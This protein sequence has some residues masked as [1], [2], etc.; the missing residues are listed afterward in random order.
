VDGTP[1]AAPPGERRDLSG[2]T[3]AGRYL[4]ERCLGVGGMGAVYVARH[5]TLGAQVA[6]K[7]LLP[8][9]VNARSMARF[10][11]EAQAASRVDHE[12]VIGVLDF[13]Q[14][15]A[16][17][18]FLVMEYV[19]GL[20][21]DEEIRRAG[22]F[23][24]ER[25]LHVLAQ[26]A[27]GLARTHELGIIHR[28]LK[29]ENVLLCERRGDR[30][31]VKLI[32][33]GL[34]KALHVEP[35]EALLT[36]EGDVFGTPEYMPPEQWRGGATDARSDIYSFGVLAY[37]L[38]TGRLPFEGD[39]S[40]LV[41][42]HLERTPIAPGR[43]RRGGG[44]PEPLERVILAAMEK[45]PERRPESMRQVLDAI[46]ET[47][48]TL[49]VRTSGASYAA[50]LPLAPSPD[51]ET[52]P[53]PTV[54]QSAALQLPWDGPAL[55]AEIARLHALHARR[56]RAL[57][58]KLFAEP[59]AQLEQLLD[60][61]DAGAQRI[62]AELAK[63]QA[64]RAE[65]ERDHQASLGQQAR[66][67]AAIIDASLQLQG[68]EQTLLAHAPPR[69]PIPTPLPGLPEQPGARREA[70][71]Q[72][73]AQVGQSWL[74][75]IRSVEQQIAASLQQIRAIDTELAPMLQQLARQVEQEARRRPELVTE[76]RELGRLRRAVTAFRALLDGITGG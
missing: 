67:R 24:I 15:D 72:M 65:L 12:N 47:L 46:A 48:V 70:A 56:L 31:F 66:L 59:V 11:R 26:I 17:D 57:A 18:Y 51:P 4:V 13:A 73:L 62:A 75:R 16:G 2:S 64:G 33:F 69:V 41:Q 45:Q 36:H 5:L 14:T 39:L 30:D 28:D 68:L 53:D 23:P 71:E 76:L 21:L 10:M 27:A 60:Q 29:P 58:G 40:E 8:D 50:T 52:V 49:P 37:E 3:I 43:R 44:V 38:V 63:I 55:A 54:F 20:P 7:L 1:L 22:P 34:A 32:D 6:I 42:A 9:R 74:E 61:A 25:A 35:G 19:S